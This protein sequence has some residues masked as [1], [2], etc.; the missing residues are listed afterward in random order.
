YQR[1][2]EYSSLVGSNE[3]VN[4]EWAEVADIKGSA[5]LL[6]QS[7]KLLLGTDVSRSI[8]YMTLSQAA[9]RGTVR[10]MRIMAI[11]QCE[12]IFL[13]KSEEIGLK[14]LTKAADWNDSVSTLA[15]LHYSNE[16]RKFN[17]SRLNQQVANTPF[18]E[19]YSAAAKAYGVADTFEVKEVSLL[20]KSFNSG[21]SNRD[22]YDP[23]CAR[24][25]YS[26]ALSFNDKER[27]LFSLNKNT[28]GVI[29]DLPLKLSHEKVLPVDVSGLLNVA[30]KRDSEVAFATQALR[31]GD[32]RSVESYRPL[33]ICSESKYLL[34]MYARAIAGNCPDVHTETIDV[35]ELNQY[36]LHPSASNI[37]VRSVDENKDNRYLL[38]LCGD[39]SEAKRDIV[40]SVI[41]SDKRAKFHLVEPGVTL[42]LSPI[43]PVC[44]CDEQNAR[45]LKA[46]CDVV[47]LGA[48][49]ASELPLAIDDIIACKQK[50]Y[51]VGDIDFAC[52]VESELVDFDVDT[53]E[54]LIDAAVRALRDC[55]KAITLTRDI[56]QKYEV[57]PQRRAIGFGGGTNGRY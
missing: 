21:A 5:I 52:D 45:W 50:L 36:D 30:I 24:V 15:L 28:L 34:N 35:A 20:E 55:G 22:V 13:G 46:Y 14:A 4:P 11:L 8:V 56:L 26:A 19:L 47:T 43:L 41:K 51:G 6:A 2:Q 17:L 23:K 53:A 38:F 27:A 33:C 16:N 1:M 31:N 39:I 57:K 37:F 9:T 18:E 54:R 40:K 49:T 3:T 10:A 42:D 12:G 44:F 32:L 7:S 29:G 48:I 25:L